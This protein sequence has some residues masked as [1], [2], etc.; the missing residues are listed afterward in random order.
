MGPCITTLHSWRWLSAQTVVVYI[1]ILAT[2][3]LP[4]L[5][6]YL[7][8]I[9]V[10]WSFP[11]VTAQLSIS[12]E[13]KRK[14]EGSGCHLCTIYFPSCVCLFVG[15]RYLFPFLFP[16]RRN[17][18]LFLQNRKRYGEEMRGY[19]MRETRMRDRGRKQN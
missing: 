10:L 3:S 7:L 5:F 13:K 6:T 4:S 14:A 11:P 2:C 12:E 15:M 17:E 19:D 18:W 1:P 9:F 8:L 16:C